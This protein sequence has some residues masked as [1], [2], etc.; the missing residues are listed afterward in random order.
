[1]AAHDPASPC[2][3]GL[4]W[5]ELPQRR[6]G[7]YISFADDE[8]ALVI[9]NNGRS[10]TFHVSDDHPLLDSILQ[11]LKHLV[12]VRKRIS[13][14]TINAVPARTSPWLGMIN[15][16]MVLVKDHKHVYAQGSL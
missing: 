5:P 2:G 11:P 6:S 4:D 9:E 14:E 1:M 7:N 3:L 10:L 16:H 13:I 15:E 12:S 8:L